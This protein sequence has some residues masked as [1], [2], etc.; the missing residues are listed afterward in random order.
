MKHKKSGSES[1]EFHNV[2]RWTRWVVPIIG[3]TVLVIVII[4]GVS[5]FLAI[6]YKEPPVSLYENKMIDRF[7]FDPD[8]QPQGECVQGKDFVGEWNLIKEH[9]HAVIGLPNGVGLYVYPS[10]PSHSVIGW[11]YVGEW[12]DGKAHGRGKYT[13]YDQMDNKVLTKCDGMFEAGLYLGTCNA[14]S[15]RFRIAPDMY[16]GPIEMDDL[17][18]H[19][20]DL[21]QGC[22]HTIRAISD[23]E[24]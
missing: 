8:V 12:V 22:D 24:D 3:L 9:P 23:Y 7:A 6:P 14:Y 19:V 17:L 20:N 1:V 21:K 11:A 15:R 4:G 18:I 16:S 10:L 5:Y 2:L 13:E